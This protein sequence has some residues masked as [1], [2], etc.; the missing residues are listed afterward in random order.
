MGMSEKDFRSKMESMTLK[1]NR[2]AHK[3]HVDTVF[4]ESSTNEEVKASQKRVKKTW[5]AVRQA[6]KIG[7]YRYE[8]KK[9]KKKKIRGLGNP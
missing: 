1:A 4:D 3:D 5:R 6:K 7:N 9:K 8:R 2:R